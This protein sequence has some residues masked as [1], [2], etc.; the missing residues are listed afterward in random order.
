MLSMLL[1][2]VSAFSTLWLW[3]LAMLRPSVGVP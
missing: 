2:A 1:L 3:L